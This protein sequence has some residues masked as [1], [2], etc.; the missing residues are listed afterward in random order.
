MS[1]QTFADAPVLKWFSAAS[2]ADLNYKRRNTHSNK[3]HGKGIHN[4]LGFSVRNESKLRYFC[5]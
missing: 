5:I 2:Y 4:K 1:K 3:R